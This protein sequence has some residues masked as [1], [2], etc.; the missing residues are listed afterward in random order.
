MR[1]TTHSGQRPI[2]PLS[3]RKTM[4]PKHPPEP[5]NSPKELQLLGWT[6]QFR[7]HSLMLLSHTPSGLVG[8]WYKGMDQVEAATPRTRFSL[9]KQAVHIRGQKR[10]RIIYTL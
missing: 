1:V 10:K 6:S 4:S 3:T 2:L 5:L 7:N 9:P 8:G